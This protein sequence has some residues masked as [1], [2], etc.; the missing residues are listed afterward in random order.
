MRSKLRDFTGVARGLSKVVSASLELQT[1][2]CSV[3]L[4][5]STVIPDVVE[6]I[7]NSATKLTSLDPV[8]CV[9]YGLD[10]VKLFG[11]QSVI[12]MK[13]YSECR[14]SLWSGGS[15]NNHLVSGSLDQNSPLVTLEPVPSL[16]TDTVVTDTAVTST[17]HNFSNRNPLPMPD[18]P[19][20]ATIS[21][22]TLD[23]AK[24]RRVPSSRI[25]R[26][27]G[28]GNLAVGLGLGAA[29]EWTKRKVGFVDN[30][31]SSVKSNP[32]L[33]DAN[34]ERI[35]DTLC[36]MRGAALKLGQMLSI[37]DESV[38][39]PKIQK[40]F[41]RVR[42][43]ADFM[44]N[45]QMQKVLVAELGS[46]WRNR[47]LQFEE[48][49]F[50]AASIGQVHRAV[51]HDGRTVAMKIQYPGV[52]D[53]IDAD[54]NNLMALLKRFDVLPHGL[55][56][57]RA[58]EVA[59]RELRAECDYKREASYC[60]RFATLLVDDSVFQ[61]PAVIDELTTRRV[62]T[63]DYMEGLV[64]DHCYALPQDVRNW[65]G[66]Q[67]LRLCLNEL[68]VFRVMQTDPNWSNFLYNPKTGKASIVL[69]D[70]GA[71]REYDKKFVDLYIQ[72]IHCAAEGDREGILTHSSSL[73]F[74]T[75]YESKVCE[76]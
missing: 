22:K 37:Q 70:F 32:F 69:L 43:A 58:V 15:S 76:I 73:G 75:G 9:L 50:A 45:R 18:S 11:K 36:R 64:L 66:E 20:E 4:D 13:K 65:I 27:A 53:S 51:L 24:E 62:L 46:D 12:V 3:W 41:E 28:F 49:P 72:L 67:L 54:I 47:I 74:L 40:M 48:Q 23:T 6:Q 8:K 71:S 2:E 57:D 29:A 35:V 30:Q 7:Q 60:K 16:P 39:N 61:V 21:T 5:H 26:I 42:Q 38:L 31:T 25:G 52:A 68:F 33:T 44:P 1:K 17:Q 34:V 14:V 56:A 59:K 63:A 19:I 10:R 55:F